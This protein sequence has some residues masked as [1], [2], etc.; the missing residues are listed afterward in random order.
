MQQVGLPL[1]WKNRRPHELSG[2][3]RQRLAIARALVTEPRVLILDE[4]LAGLDLSVQGQI[5]NLLIDLQIERSLSYLYITH[6][7]ELAARVA[8]E[9]AIL[10]QGRIVRRAPPET[11]MANARLASTVLGRSDA[12]DLSLG[13]HMGA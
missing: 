6:D 13:A 3:Q 4:A 1:S 10:Y 7:V 8:D 5:V 12:S 11:F 9:V 2:G